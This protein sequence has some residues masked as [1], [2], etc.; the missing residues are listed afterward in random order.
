MNDTVLLVG[1][2]AAFSF[3][4]RFQVERFIARRRGACRLVEELRERL[5]S[6]RD[7]HDG[8]A[9]VRWAKL[10]D[11]PRGMIYEITRP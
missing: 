8:V 7:D 10:R 11:S 6:S 3:V 5:R 9:C 2:L 4:A 1:A